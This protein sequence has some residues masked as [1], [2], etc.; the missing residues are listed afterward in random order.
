MA[1]VQVEQLLQSF[2]KGTTNFDQV[3]IPQAFLAGSFLPFI[4][5]EA[6]RLYQANFRHAV[7]PGAI[8][9]QAYL[10]E[11][12]FEHANLLGAD[13]SLANLH[14]AKLNH[15]LLAS[16]TLT[17]STLRGASLMGTRLANADLSWA[18]LRNTNLIGA[19]LQGTDLSRAN[20]FGARLSP[21][22]LE[23][24]ILNDTMMPSGQRYTGAWQDYRSI[25]L[26]LTTAQRRMTASPCSLQTEYEGEATQAMR[27]AYRG[28]PLSLGP[29]PSSQIGSCLGEPG[30]QK[31]IGFRISETNADL[32]LEI[33]DDLATQDKGNFIC[34]NHFLEV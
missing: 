23:H 17:R 24:A 27:L 34:I 15:S 11:T 10:A 31:I 7:L 12:N 3:V 22:G 14:Q 13:L 8:M 21:K 32:V 33:L 16:A 5:F 9:T 25:P 20:L 29:L 26:A 30:Q 4:S 19:N 2:H 1:T 6:A 18:D 28:S